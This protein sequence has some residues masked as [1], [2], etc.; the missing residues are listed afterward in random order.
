MPRSRHERTG[1]PC[2]TGFAKQHPEGKEKETTKSIN[3]DHFPT[4]AQNLWQIGDERMKFLLLTVMG[5]IAPW[6]SAKIQVQF[7]PVPITMQTF[8]VLAVGMAFGWHLGTAMVLRYLAEGAL[9]PLVFAGT[10]EFGIGLA[11][12]A[13]PTGGY[14]P[15]FLV[16]AAMAGWR[17]EAGIGVAPRSWQPWRWAPQSSMLLA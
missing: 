4:L 3:S 9:S 10:P 6:L 5:N 8:V 1:R 16:A 17:K 7:Y 12:M 2:L 14:L 11:Y 15:G 13:G